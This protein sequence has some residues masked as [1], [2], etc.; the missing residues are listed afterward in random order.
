MSNIFEK[1]WKSV[2]PKAGV[3]AGMGVGFALGGPVG[4]IVGG[5]AGGVGDS[6]RAEKKMKDQQKR[7]TKKQ[8]DEYNAALLAQL[9][10]EGLLEPPPWYSPKTTS[11]KLLIGSGVAVAG[12]AGFMLMK[13]KR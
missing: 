6:Q 8:Q 2:K 13:R 11:G 7:M 10:S 12:L 5:V 4:A 1:A 9:E 3:I